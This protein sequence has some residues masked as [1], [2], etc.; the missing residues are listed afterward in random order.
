MWYWYCLFIPTKMDKLISCF[1][2]FFIWNF[3]DYIQTVVSVR[4]EDFLYISLKLSNSVPLSDSRKMF[5]AFLLKYLTFIFLNITILK[6]SFILA[7]ATSYINFFNFLKYIFIEKIFFYKDI[8]WKF[9]IK[10]SFLES[11]L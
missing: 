8:F 9:W 1:H 2:Q 6:I 5:I 4:Q 10:F 7:R 3:I 11:Y